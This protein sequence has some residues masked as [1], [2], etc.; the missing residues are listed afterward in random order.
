MLGIQRVASAGSLLGM[1]PRDVAV[2]GSTEKNWAWGGKQV[3]VSTWVW[4]DVYVWSI[5]R[6]ESQLST[7]WIEFPED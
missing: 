3:I 7:C 5:S 1:T 6:L 4:G 2:R